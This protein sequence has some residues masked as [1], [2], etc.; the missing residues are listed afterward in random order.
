MQP[1][2]LFAVERNPDRA[3]G[4][5][6]YR[7]RHVWYVHCGCGA[8]VFEVPVDVR[9]HRRAEEHMVEHGKKLAKKR[10][11]TM[12]P[13]QRLIERRFKASL[14]AWIAD[15]RQTGSFLRAVLENDLAKAM[16]SGDGDAIDNLPH[17]VAYLVTDAPPDCWGSV[18][19]VAEW[20]GMVNR[21]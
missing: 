9:T 5:L 20:K 1:R 18:S 17:V 14:D 11:T 3:G 2:D 4:A 8:H 12:L 10:R 7:G 21:K 16:A 6:D 15:G 19:A 13:D